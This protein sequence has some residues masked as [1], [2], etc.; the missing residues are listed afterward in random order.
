MIRS[1]KCTITVGTF[2]RLH[3]SVLSEVPCQLIRTSKFPVASFP[4]T[5]IRFFSRVCPLVCLEM[6]ALGINLGTTR[7][8]AAVDPLVALGRLGIVV[9]CVH[10]LIGI[11]GGCRMGGHHGHG[12]ASM[13]LLG[14]D[15]AGWVGGRWCDGI[16]ME[17]SG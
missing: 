2:E 7:V 6:R 10:Q 12:I 16:V 4:V 8:G 15:W 5:L 14:H 13:L 3:T 17:W 9:H 11:I 1:G